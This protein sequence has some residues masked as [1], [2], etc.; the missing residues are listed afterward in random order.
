MFFV[1]VKIAVVFLVGWRFGLADFSWERKVYDAGWA[2]LGSLFSFSAPIGVMVCRHFEAGLIPVRESPH[3]GYVKQQIESGD[4]PVPDDSKKKWREYV[5][6][7]HSFSPNELGEAERKFVGLIECVT[8]GKDNFEILVDIDWKTGRFRVVDGFHRLACLAVSKPSSPVTCRLY[9][10]PI[11]RATHWTH[12]D[13][14][15]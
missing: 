14:R 13:K 12:P 9:G 7:Q 10:W 11:Q 5:V 15:I 4:A 1:L 3:Y 2:R 8:E 6:R